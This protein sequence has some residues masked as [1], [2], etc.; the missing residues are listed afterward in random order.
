M[1]KNKLNSHFN[2]IRPPRYLRE[3]LEEANQLLSNQKPLEALDHFLELNHKYPHNPE[4]LESMAFAYV[5]LKNNYGFLDTMLQ[6]NDLV[7]DRESIKLGLADA[8]LANEFQALAFQT[9]RQI[10][11]RWP[12]SENTARVQKIIQQM[13]QFVIETS[14]KLDFSLE[15]GLDFFAKHEEIQLLM[16]RG[17]FKRCKQLAKELLNQ[18]PEFAPVRNNLSQISWLEGN[19][20]EAIEITQKVL[21]S[22]PENVHALS[23]LCCYFFMLGKKENLTPL[24]KRLKE[25]KILATDYWLKKVKALSFI[26]DDDSVIELLE[27]AKLDRNIKLIDGTFWHWSAVAEYRRGHILKARTYWKK[28]LNVTPGFSLASENL[29]ELKKPLF[30]QT[31]PQAFSLETWLPK[32]IIEDLA[33]I[34][35]HP[36]AENEKNSSQEKL[37]LYFAEHPEILQFIP[38]ALTEGDNF[39][40]EFA[41]QLADMASNPIINNWLTSFALGKEGPDSLRLKAAQ[42]LAK[43]G[44]FESG[45]KVDLWSKGELRPVLM[46]GFEIIFESLDKETLQPSARNLMEEAIEAIREGNG[47]KAESHLRKAIEIQPNEP[48][49]L[50]NLAVSLQ[51]QR[52]TSEANALA[53]QIEKDFPDYFFGQL[54]AARKSILAKDFNKTK[55]ILDKLIK[56]DK[57]HITEFSAFCSCQIDFHIADK[58]IEGAI[59]WL[60]IWEKVYPEDPSLKKYH[61]LRNLTKAHSKLKN[62]NFNKSKFNKKPN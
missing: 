52:K 4:I 26:G 1:S 59:S 42:I 21:D 33:A 56:K 58:N 14:S 29:N 36:S 2:P 39:A 38:A 41:L 5:D 60:Q 61:E 11:R 35:K 12:C 57:L 19:L 34:F 3:G 20:T 27:Q 16:N 50:N 37:D 10:F 7:S 49:L 62:G 6:L 18:R 44:I 15:P 40:R 43:H 54:I 51:L 48:S 22:Q 9:Y 45:K 30:D 31:C 13:E 47:K 23:T 55:I 28:C 17:K 32:K 24:V 25:S 53:D 46:F 8:Y